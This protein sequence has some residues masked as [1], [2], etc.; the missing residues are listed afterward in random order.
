M[1]QSED[2]S[3]SDDEP[4]CEVAGCKYQMED[5]DRAPCCHVPLCERHYRKLVK[6]WTCSNESCG[7]VTHKCQVCFDIQGMD[8]E[9]SQDEK[10]ST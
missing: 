2:S 3:S 6:Y 1:S 7:Y 8:C 4:T 9:C 10:E 5:W